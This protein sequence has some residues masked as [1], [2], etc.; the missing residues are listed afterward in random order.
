MV[1]RRSAWRNSKTGGCHR[2]SGK[3]SEGRWPKL[4]DGYAIGTTC[5]LAGSRRGVHPPVMRGHFLVRTGAIF[6]VFGLAVA[7]FVG[8]A[9]ST[10]AAAF[11]QGKEEQSENN[12]QK[13][14]DAKSQPQQAGPDAERSLKRMEM[15]F[16]SDQKAIW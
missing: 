1:V 5:F 13:Q 12:A 3:S 15:D 10:L 4:V 11:P 8:G 9:R 6:L 16:L 2:R 14:P 7:S